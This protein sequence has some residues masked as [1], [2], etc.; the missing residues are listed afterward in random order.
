M[1]E[2]STL[3]HGELYWEPDPFRRYKRPVVARLRYEGLWKSDFFS[4]VTVS[5]C[6]G[7]KTEDFIVP[8]HVVDEGTRTVAAALVGEQGDKILVRFPPTNFDTSSFKAA[9]EDLAR[10]TESS[11]YA[12]K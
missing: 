8:H 11:F 3:L 1:T 9:Y 12:G 5:L 6:V 2:S 7:E 4:E 10:I